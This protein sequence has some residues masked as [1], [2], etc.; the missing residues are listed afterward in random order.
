MVRAACLYCGAALPKDAVAAAAESAALAAAPTGSAPLGVLLIVDQSFADAA[1]LGAA[2]GLLP[3]ESAL[4]QKRGGYSLEG[5]MDPAGAEEEAAR[6]RA[7]GL[8]VFLVPESR[9]RAEPFVAV[10]GVPEEDGLRLRGVSGSRHVSNGDLLLVVRGS[11]AREHQAPVEQKKI[12]TARLE[13]GYRFHLHV[14]S[15]PQ[16][17]ELDPGDFDFG[18]RAPLFGSSLL[19]MR[20]WLSCVTEGAPV[21]DAFRHATPA[22]GPS[23]A[24]AGGPLAAAAALSAGASARRRKGDGA[25]HDNLRQFRFYSAWRGEL[26]RARVDP[27]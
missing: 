21:D 7:A 25:V 9:A 15:S 2:L 8:R 22:L 26:E 19:E 13:Y 3:Y 27:E 20:D 18:P 12:R 16:V 14:R 5:V 6:L 10:A 17:V 4:R 11:I 23:P 24:G 1:I